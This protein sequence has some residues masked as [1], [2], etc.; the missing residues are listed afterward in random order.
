M[1][2][3]ET[4]WNKKKLV[5]GHTDI[6]LNLEG[7][8][9]VKSLIKELKNVK[10]DKAYSSDLLRAKRTA[11][12]IAIEHKIEV[13][14][15]KELRERNYAHFEG[16]HKSRLE[17]VHKAIALLNKKE[18]LLYKHHPKIES[19]KEVMDRFLSYLKQ[20]AVSNKNK[21]VLVVSH[22]GPIW[23]MLSML[24]KIDTDGFIRIENLG[25]L[26]L[27]FDGKNFEIKKMKRIGLT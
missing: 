24:K 1:R 20:I 27:G 18:K 22:G 14:C 11:E 21:T 16:K 9:K 15:A 13:E 26:V 2:H 4:D 3:G 5:Q 23:M 25:Y 19:I 10:F 12:I 6:P 8:K 17:E 7:E